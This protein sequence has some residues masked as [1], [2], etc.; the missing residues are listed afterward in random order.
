MKIEL[1]KVVSLT[2]QIARYLW[3]KHGHQEVVGFD[4]IA[5]ALLC[6][7][8][9]QKKDY[10]NGGLI[11]SSYGLSVKLS[12]TRKR[13]RTRLLRLSLFG[14]VKVETSWRNDGTSK[15]RPMQVFPNPYLFTLLG[16]E[17]KQ[18]LKAQAVKY[19]AALGMRR[20]EGF[21]DDVQGFSVD[22]PYGSNEPSDNKSTIEETSAEIE[23][24][25]GEMV[26][27]ADLESAR[28]LKEQIAWREYDEKFVA[29][30]AKM[31]VSLQSAMGYGTS[32]PNWSGEQSIMP[33][34][35]KRERRELTKVFQQYGCKVAA[36]AWYIFAGGQ[37]KLDNQGKPEFI[38]NVP[39]RQY[40]SVDKKP[41]QF[42][43]HFN[44]I[45]N[46]G[47]FKD[48]SKK[49]WYDIEAKLKSYYSE[50]WDVNPRDC[51]SYVEKLGYELGN[52]EATLGDVNNAISSAIQGS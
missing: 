7:L 20:L 26:E 18:A 13:I 37:A 23:A 44:A 51:E 49:G 10:K 31:W 38:P 50:I 11:I 45:L 29:G 47:Y 43:K 22:H 19:F 9:N 24:K 12:T 4:P 39:H 46:D 40:A 32:E 15:R 1:Q 27:A 36:L 6:F 33:V 41:S 8:L 3:T 21:D 28:K 34:Q 52:T 42:S 17:S 2:S 48:F 25:L 30:S 16:K 14:L 35:A 5:A